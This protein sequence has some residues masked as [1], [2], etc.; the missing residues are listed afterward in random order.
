MTSSLLSDLP[1]LTPAFIYHPLPDFA[2]RNNTYMEE[3]K[4]LLPT[5]CEMRNLNS[6]LLLCCCCVAP[7]SV[8]PGSAEATARVICCSLPPASHTVMMPNVP[9]I[10]M[11]F[12][13]LNVR[14][15]TD[16][17]VI[18][19]VLAR[20]GEKRFNTNVFVLLEAADKFDENLI[21]L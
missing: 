4:S 17:S 16:I 7:S 21:F 20:K 13:I 12:C 15:N 1:S 6:S 19:C 10:F 3:R 11:P 14:T 8:W 5:S 18:A 2:Y 9:Q